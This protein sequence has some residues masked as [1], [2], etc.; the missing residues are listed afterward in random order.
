MSFSRISKAEIWDGNTLGPQW[1]FWLRYRNHKCSSPLELAHAGT[2]DVSKP[3][4][5]SRRGVE[6]KLWKD[7]IQSR[8]L[9]LFQ[10][11]E[12]S[13]LLRS[14]GFTD[15][16]TLKCRNFPP[17]GQLLVDELGGLAI[18]GLVRLVPHKLR[19]DGFCRDVAQVKGASRLASKFVDGSPRF[20]TRVREVDGINS[21]LPSLLLLL[22]KPR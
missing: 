6:Y 19:D 2:E 21:F 18:L 10:A 1:L 9:S 13:K 22:I 14:K 8:R 16:V 11:S 5:E 3:R 12:G 17:V 7:E 15:T 4:F 20:A